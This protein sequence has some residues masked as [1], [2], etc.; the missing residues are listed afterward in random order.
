MSLAA[1]LAELNIDPYEVLGVPLDADL[2]T[3]KRTYRRIALE[4]HP[5]RNPADPNCE[6]RFK[7]ATAAF[8]ILSDPQKRAEYNARRRYV[9]EEG[10]VWFHVSK[11]PRQRTSESADWSHL[12]WSDFN[13]GDQINDYQ[14][15]KQPFLHAALRLAQSVGR[16]L[17]KAG[18][19]SK[20]HI[21]QGGPAVSGEVYA[22]YGR[23]GVDIL[24]MYGTCFGEGP[25]I[26]VQIPHDWTMGNHYINPKSPPSHIADEVFRYYM[27][28]IKTRR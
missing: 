16:I 26:L 20:A 5:D 23:N 7:L 17:K 11:R 9:P 27:Q 3:I 2:T 13:A 25:C 19:T 21:N 28:Y 4:C 24:V 15:N 22:H 18:F 14:G 12:T 8:E 6:E 10:P 1:L